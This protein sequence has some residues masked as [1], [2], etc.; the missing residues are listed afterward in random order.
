MRS[1][2]ERT[3]VT[4]AAPQRRYLWTDA[5]AVCNFVGLARVTGDASLDD[6][7]TRLIDRV[8]HTLGRHRGDDGRSGW[9]SGLSEEEGAARPTAGGLRIGKSLPERAPDEPYDASLEWDRDGQY[10]HYLTRWMHALDVAARARRDVQLHRH[11]RDLARV[12]FERF[13][14]G[15][16]MYWKMSIDL[17]RPLVASMGHHDP[18]DGLVTCL[19]IDETAIALGE[20]TTLGDAIDWLSSIVA[21]QDLSTDDAL[22]LGGLLADASRVAQLG[23]HPQL[24]RQLIDAALEGLDTFGHELRSPAESRLAFRELGL[25][26][27]LRAVARV[28]EPALEPYVPL[29]EEITAFWRRPEHRRV[30][31]WTE[32]Q[33]IDD[34]M[35]ATALVPDGFVTL[36]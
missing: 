22:G 32:H 19:Q 16:R 10:F 21:G 28:N 30:E 8:H 2:A 24:L 4:S 20:K 6:L 5:F 33:D 18:L 9:L 3:G 7:A 15:R 31:S 12:A 23:G 11:A 17:S 29:N 26:I 14:H 36:P 27:G 25:A 13:T 35:L 1:F 34:V